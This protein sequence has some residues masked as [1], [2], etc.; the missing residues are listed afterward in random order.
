MISWTIVVGLGGAGIALFIVPI[1]R[2]WRD[3]E[4][5]RAKELFHLQRERLEAKFFELARLSGKPKDM[6]W[7]EC[8][9]ADPAI[10]MRDRKTNQLSALVGV[11]IRFSAVAGG[12]MENVAAVRNLRDATAVFHYHRGQWG[13]GGRALLNMTPTE[14]LTHFEQQYEPLICGDPSDPARQ[15]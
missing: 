3:V 12:R 1:R 4:G 14:A 5:E 13:T 7:E 8:D 9:F 2:F 11:T 10:F 15:P 6:I